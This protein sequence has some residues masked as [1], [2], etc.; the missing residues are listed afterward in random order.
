[1]PST[2]KTSYIPIIDLLRGVAAISVC[3]FHFI[4]ETKFFITGATIIYLFN[5]GHY[6]VH[7]FFVISGMVIPLSMI[8]GNYKYNAFPKF[9]W[10]RFLRIEPPYLVAVLTGTLV[11]ILRNHVPGTVAVD[12]IPSVKALLLHVGYLVPFYDTKLWINPVFWTL[13]IEF[14][15]YIA[16]SILF[17]LV[18]RSDLPSRLL[19]YAIFLSSCFWNITDEFLPVWMPLF[20][21]GI[22]YILWLSGK[23]S[24]KEYWLITIP[25][26]F[27]VYW[28][29]DFPSLVVAIC[30]L[31]A[32]HFFSNYRNRISKFF[33]NI[34]Y[35]LYL[36]HSI[37]G[38]AFV[39]YLSH[40]A[41]LGWQ[42]GLIVMGGFILSVLSAYLLHKF[43]EKPSQDLSSKV[44]Y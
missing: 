32:V 24:A 15:Y 39:N 11:L 3:F 31:G 22:L 23:I 34:S 25:A 14:Q 42:K 30:T 37:I 44:K 9:L 43:V 33:G 4:C 7:L 8:K 20:L 26:M 17:P 29:I 6:G 2:N 12:K 18:L 38:A 16:L 28:K 35:S 1:M 21:V 40:H 36:L 10:K 13:A 5:F 27:L 41:H 19:F